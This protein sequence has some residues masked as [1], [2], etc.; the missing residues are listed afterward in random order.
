MSNTEHSPGEWVVVGADI[1]SHEAQFDDSGARIGNTP[2]LIA[3]V[4]ET[5]ETWLG[6]TKEANAELLAA[7]PKL[8]AACEYVVNYHREH[9]SGEGELFGLDFVTTCIN[10]IREAKPHW[11]LE[12]GTNHASI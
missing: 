10:A 4:H 12:K 5:G 2:N 6:V 1:H 7:S 3:T 8:L 9:D 11:Q